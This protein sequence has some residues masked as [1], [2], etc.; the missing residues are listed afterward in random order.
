MNKLTS[1]IKKI[2]SII[3]KATFKNQSSI[4]NQNIIKINLGR[5]QAKINLEKKYKNINDYEFKIFS[6]FGEDGII[7][8]L[9]QNLEISNNKYIEFGVENY[10]EANTRFLLENNNWKGLII[11]NSNENIRHIKNQSYY[12][13][14]DLLAVQSSLSTKNINNIILKNGFDGDIG[15][16]SIDIDGNDYW[17]LKEINVISPDIIIIEYNAN[18]GRDKSLT[19]KYNEHFQRAKYGIEKLIYG[20][21]LTAA[22]NLCKEKGYTLVCTNKN[23]NNAFFVKTKLLNEKIVKKTVKEAFNINSFK[24]YYDSSGIPSKISAQQIYE[25]NNSP[26]VQEV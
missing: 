7:Q 12:W 6:Q 24:E 25:I 26:L 17:I 9:I 4:E 16:L 10:E 5:I 15:L 13:R 18:Y 23:G 2:F 3:C 19:I 11:D 8:H 14:H 21:S 1:K 20:C 22:N